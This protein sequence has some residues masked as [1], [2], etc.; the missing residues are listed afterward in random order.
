MILI[1]IGITLLA[2]AADV[3]LKTGANQAGDALADPLVLIRI[4]WIWLGAVTGLTA[5]SLWIYVLSKHNISH[6]YPIFVGLTFLNI[7]LASSIYLGEEIGIT[8]LTGMLL[9]M[10][11]IVTIHR[12]SHDSDALAG[13]GDAG[14]GAD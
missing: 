4:P 6:A 11:G 10:A 12:Y 8:R 13:D 5:M 3:L 1:L 14:G 2:S 7:S 9:V